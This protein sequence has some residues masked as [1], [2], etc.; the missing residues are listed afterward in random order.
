MIDMIVVALLLSSAVTAVA[1]HVAPRVDAPAGR[2]VPA[3]RVR[4][5]G[6]GEVLTSSQPAAAAVRTA[7][8]VHS[9]RDVPV[10][11]DGRIS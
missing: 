9:G 7:D 3:E 11:P 10:P 1:D 2:A 5:G 6:R 4:P 8:G